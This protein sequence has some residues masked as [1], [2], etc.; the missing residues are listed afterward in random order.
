M[1]VWKNCK[2]QA[3]I[4]VTI[5]LFL[6]DCCGD[7]P[8]EEEGISSR[9]HWLAVLA[10]NATKTTWRLLLV[11]VQKVSRWKSP[12]MKCCLVSG[13]LKRKSTWNKMKLV[14]YERIRWQHVLFCFFCFFIDV[15]NSHIVW[16]V[17]VVAIKSL[18]WK[19]K[20]PEI[21]LRLVL[22][23]LSYKS[24]DNDNRSFFFFIVQRMPVE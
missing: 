6:Q 14:F 17:R 19:G 18:P 4:N 5:V 22:S 7:L 13:S 9:W 24:K 20:S 2:L 1:A 12:E 16:C 3:E 10:S 8:P 11:A 23:F 21:K 15:E